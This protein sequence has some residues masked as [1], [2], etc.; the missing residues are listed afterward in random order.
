MLKTGFKVYNMNTNAEPANYSEQ[1]AGWFCKIK[2]GL[3]NVYIYQTYD[4]LIS[5]N[6]QNGTVKISEDIKDL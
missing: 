5:V 1:N 2:D 3:H 4:E 6:P